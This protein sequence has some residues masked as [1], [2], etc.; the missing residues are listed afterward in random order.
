MIIKDIIDYLEELA[1]LSYSLE[2]DNCGLQIGNKFN[3]VK[4]IG[5]ALTTT[6]EII[7]K[8]IEKNCNFLITHHPLIF[9]PLKN[10]D[11]SDFIGKI[12]KT[13]LKND[14][15]IYTMHTNFDSSEQGLN[16]EIAKKIGLDNISILS[17]TREIEML[18]LVTFVPEDY[19][20]SVINSVSEEGA[21]R[22]GKLSH[23]SYI[24]AG[25][26]TF[27]E[28]KD[29]KDNIE[30]PNKETED[31]LEIIVPSDKLN[32]V[33]KKLKK[34]HPYED[35]EIVYDIYK[36][37]NHKKEVGIGV[38]GDFYTPFKFEEILNLVKDTLNLNKFTYIG[39][40]DKLI[41]RVAICTGSGGSLLKEVKKKGA[42]LYITGDIK[43]HTAIDAKEMNL[44]IIDAGHYYTE[45]LFLPFIS[46]YLSNF[47]NE[48]EIIELKENDP[49]NYYY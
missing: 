43:Y 26:A 35:N 37:D 45:I 25:I 23:C 38:I 11:T 21:G 31:K 9:K 20:I 34:A 41:K 40:K 2:W 17:V 29:K 19:T 48:H 32:K 13:S 3:K 49:F 18:K 22:I 47:V 16:Y 46:K 6:T 15:T 7:E 42:D 28:D 12:I 30:I 27:I 36:L 14:I 24:T 39:E 44:C 10:I 4:N 5:I 33:L 1:P 8:A